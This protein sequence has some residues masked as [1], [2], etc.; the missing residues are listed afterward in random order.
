M[1]GRTRFRSATAASRPQAGFSIIEVLIAAVVMGF[2]ALALIPLFTMAMSSNLQAQDHTNV[3]NHA[4]DRFETLWRFSFNHDDLEILA[5]EERVH[6]EHYS[7]QEKR[8][9]PGATPAS[10]DEAVFARTT[11]IRQFGIND[12]VNPLAAGADPAR[13]HLK[14]LTVEVAHARPGPMGLNKA[15]TIRAFKAE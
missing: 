4:R 1:N 13:I 12:L 8:W 10:G 15:I 11:R 3:A 9:L 7:K 5:G 2:I 14:E 6:E